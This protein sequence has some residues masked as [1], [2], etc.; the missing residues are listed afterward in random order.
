MN[1]N[2]EHGRSS[3]LLVKCNKLEDECN[4][5][6]DTL[7]DVLLHSHLDV[8]YESKSNECGSVDGYIKIESIGCERKTKT[9]PH[10]VKHLAHLNSKNV[11]KYIYSLYYYYIFVRHGI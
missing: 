4:A 1:S 7:K 2:G 6:W 10:I 11:V 3:E 5:L 8:Q 9:K